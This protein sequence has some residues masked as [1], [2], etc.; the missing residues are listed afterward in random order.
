MKKVKLR[1]LGTAKWFLGIRILRDRAAKKLWLCQDTYVSK[2]ASRFN[3]RSDQR[4]ADTPLQHTVDLTA[5]PP[6]KE[7]TET[8]NLVYS[9]Q[10]KVGSIQYAAVITRPDIAKAASLLAESVTKP[11]P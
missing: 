8:P 10:Q 6:N 7:E 5:I 4:L 2:L 11:T 3:L 1:E 9:Y